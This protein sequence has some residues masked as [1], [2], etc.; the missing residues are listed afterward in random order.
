MSRLRFEFP[1]RKPNESFDDWRARVAVVEQQMLEAEM[2]A[3]LE[4]I[5]MDREI[6]TNNL[7]LA[8]ARIQFVSPS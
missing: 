5:M 7:R 8:S 3:D 1:R 2:E 6:H 4:T